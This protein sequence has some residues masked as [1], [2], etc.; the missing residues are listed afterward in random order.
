METVF[1]AEVIGSMLRPASLKQAREEYQAG[2]LSTDEFKKIEDRAVDQVIALQ[3]GAGVDVVTDGE[4]RRVLFMG[5][6]FETVDGMEPVDDHTLPWHTPDGA[7]TE[8]NVPVVATSKLRKRRSGVPEEFCYAR[9]RARSPLKVTIP[10]PL[11]LFPFWSP[12][13]STKAYSDAFEFFADGVDIVRSDAQELA[14]LG[15][16]Y[17]QVDA[18][19]LA[20]LVDPAVCQWYT[21]MGM[22]P[23]RLLTEGLD[24]INAAVADIPGVTFGIHLCRGNNAGMWMSS[25]GYD[26]IA[27]ALFERTP[28]YDVYLLEYDDHRSGSFEPLASAND[29]KVIVLGLV[30]SK[31]S[32]L[33]SREELTARVKAGRPVLPAGTNGPVHTMRLRFDHPGQPHRRGSRREQATPGGR[34]RPSNLE[35]TPLAGGPDRVRHRGRTRHSSPQQQAARRRGPAPGWASPVRFGAADDRSADALGQGHDDPLRTAHVGHAPDVLVLADAA[36]QPVALRGQPVDGRLEVVD[37][38]GHIAQPQLVGHRGGRSGPVGG[39]DEAREL[40][41]GTSVGRPQ[42]DDLGAGVGDAAD[43]VQELAFHERPA[44]DLETQPDEERRRRVEVSNGDTDMI[45]TSYT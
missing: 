25:G 14:A 12:K 20:T 4:M 21:S 27:K 34:R 33:E 7:D 16:T 38:E 26:S 43:R 8:W 41:P 45:E 1:R 36:D 44:L 15:C 24:M 28:A 39:P 5:P 13:Y 23:E 30:S 2:R 10:S 29:D 22:P 17:I 37:L 11:M 6:L 40:Q 35:L 18:P 3:E 19:E 42:H 32:D 31:K 9:G